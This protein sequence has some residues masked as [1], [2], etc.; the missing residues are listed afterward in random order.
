MTF[1]SFENGARAR[2]HLAE[3]LGDPVRDIGL[4]EMMRLWRQD[5][6]T[7]SC[8]RPH[9]LEDHP[10]LAIRLRGAL[11]QALARQGSPVHGRSDPF[12]RPRAFDVLFGDAVAPS[13]QLAGRPMAV[14]ADVIGDRIE[15]T[16]RLFGSAGFWINQVRDGL[17]DAL[18]QGVSLRPDSRVRIPFEVLGSEQHRA[19]L[20]DDTPDC[21]SATLMFRTPLV[22]RAGGRL[23]ERQGALVRSTARRIASLAK[24]HGVRLQFDDERIEHGIARMESEDELTMVQFWRNSRRQPGRPIPVKGKIGRIGLSKIS[25]E[26]VCLF[27]IGSFTHTGSHAALGFGRFDLAL[28]P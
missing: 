10:D 7:V 21:R 16:V 26:L 13:G 28:Y 22:I 27:H 15:I 20:R 3:F 4:S 17:L 18:R 19:G 5:E 12:N 1:S 23:S 2:D 11:G 6:I 14:A 9:D 8:R 24:W 25:H